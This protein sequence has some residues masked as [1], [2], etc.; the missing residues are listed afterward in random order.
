M[1]YTIKAVKGCFDGNRYGNS[2][3]CANGALC[4]RPLH[5][6][7]PSPFRNKRSCLTRGRHLWFEVD[8]FLISFQYTLI[9]ADRSGSSKSLHYLAP[10]K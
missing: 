10:Q 4:M 6:I 9:C 7:N 3:S 1:A 8:E 5:L 2:V